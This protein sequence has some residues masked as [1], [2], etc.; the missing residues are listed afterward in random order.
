MKMMKNGMTGRRWVHVFRNAG[1]NNIIV[2]SGLANRCPSKRH[3]KQSP[4]GLT[5][6]SFD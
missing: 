5:R 4:H 3:E 2:P 6:D 1:E